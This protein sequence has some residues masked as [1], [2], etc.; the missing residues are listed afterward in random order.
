M[1]KRLDALVQSLQQAHA[2]NLVSVVLYG[3]TVT[4]E[5]VQGR[6]DHNVLVVLN[7]ITP[8]DLRA[9]HPVAEKW[10]KQ[11]NPLPLYFTQEEMKRASDVFP[12]EFLDMSRAHRVLFGPDP[13]DGLEVPQRNLRHQLEYEL[14]GKLIRLRELYIPASHDAKRLSTLMAD[15]LN[16]FTILF[17]HA[18]GLWGEESPLTKR[19]V[20]TRLSERVGIDPTPFVNVFELHERGKKLSLEQAT[21]YFTAYL[22][23]LEVVIHRV[24][25]VPE[26]G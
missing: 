20:L 22:A 6:S 23:A 16:S 18:L 12:I 19:E 26:A 13:F 14:R 2:E 3:S 25:E 15:S 21:E 9:A 24:D 5:H 17:R 7:Q 4:G 11:G 8:S 10:H 1:E